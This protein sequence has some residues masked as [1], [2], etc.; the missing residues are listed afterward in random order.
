MWCQY[1]HGH[2]GIRYELYQHLQYWWR[3]L[4]NTGD[5]RILYYSDTQMMGSV[6]K[7]KVKNVVFSWKLLLWYCGDLSNGIIAGIVAEISSKI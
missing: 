6:Y 2:V 1:L 5:V 4:T 3:S 7:K